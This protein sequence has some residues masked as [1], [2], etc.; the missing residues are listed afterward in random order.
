MYMPPP[1]CIL[2]FCWHS[3]QQ[4]H[5]YAGLCFS[6]SYAAVSK[7]RTYTQQ[8]SM[9][10]VPIVP[11]C[12]M[13]DCRMHNMFTACRTYNEHNVHCVHVKSLCFDANYE[14]SLLLFEICV[15]CNVSLK[16]YGKVLYP[17]VAI[18]KFMVANREY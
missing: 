12:S 16:I 5:E 9:Y 4:Q 15:F 6:F 1:I 10:N 14:V 18:E 7:L 13:S 11:D 2:V 8:S 3:D 17:N